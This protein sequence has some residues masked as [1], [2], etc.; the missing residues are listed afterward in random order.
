MKSMTCNQHKN[1]LHKAQRSSAMSEYGKDQ[2]VAQMKRDNMRRECSL[3][4][5]LIVTSACSPTNF[6][7]TGSIAFLILKKGM[8]LLVHSSKADSS[9]AGRFQGKAVV[10][11]KYLDQKDHWFLDPCVLTTKKAPKS[12]FVLIKLLKILLFLFHTTQAKQ[13]NRSFTSFMSYN[14]HIYR[15]NSI[16]MYLYHHQ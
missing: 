15:L 8:V 1:A 13:R 10:S 14:F 6:L 12:F 3:Y 9:A 5:H 7:R 2:E 4:K 16:I 11:G